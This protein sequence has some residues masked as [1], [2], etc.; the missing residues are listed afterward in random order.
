MQPSSARVIEISFPSSALTR[1]IL[2]GLA[3]MLA[4]MVSFDTSGLL[5]LFDDLKRRAPH[6]TFSHAECHRR[7]MEA[8]ARVPSA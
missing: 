1:S 2:S 4:T 7:S 3:W 5:G 6:G 8:D